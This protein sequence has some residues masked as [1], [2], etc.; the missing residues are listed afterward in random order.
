MISFMFIAD[1]KAEFRDGMVQIGWIIDNGPEPAAHALNPRSIWQ[2]LQ[3]ARGVRIDDIG[4]MVIEE[5]WTDSGGDI[6]QPTVIDD[7]L[8]YNVRVDGSLAD[9]QIDGRAEVD[10]QGEVRSIFARTKVGSQF[11]NQLD[12]G[13]ATLIIVAEE[14]AITQAQI[15]K[16]N[17]LPPAEQR[18]ALRTKTKIAPGIKFQGVTLLED[19]EKF[20]GVATPRRDWA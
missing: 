13:N 17:A 11:K 2:K 20:N 14:D 16:Y 3:P 6:I 7:R 15:D 8:H 10:A 9:E 4:P 5:M 18:K 12:A 1:T 19:A